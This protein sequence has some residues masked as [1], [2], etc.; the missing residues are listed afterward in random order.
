MGLVPKL[1][2]ALHACGENQM[3]HRICG[4]FIKHPTLLGFARRVKG[5]LSILSADK[6]WFLASVSVIGF[7]FY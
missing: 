7:N 6:Q 3:E 1:G 4:I 5:Y 2:L